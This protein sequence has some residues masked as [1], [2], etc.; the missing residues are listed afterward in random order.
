MVS[1]S[2]MV[3]TN[4]KW[5]LLQKAMDRHWPETRGRDTLK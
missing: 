2:S 1:T 5:Q 4:E 3:W